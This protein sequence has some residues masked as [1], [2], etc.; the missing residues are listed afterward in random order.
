MNKED[1]AAVQLHLGE[2]DAFATARRILITEILNSTAKILEQKSILRRRMLAAAPKNC[3]QWLKNSSALDILL[4]YGRIDYEYYYD[5]QGS[6]RLGG[7]REEVEARL[8]ALRLAWNDEVVVE[9]QDNG[10]RMKYSLAFKY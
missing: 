7:N 5:D 8:T 10:A 2:I 3:Q 4:E 1:V 9:W 6:E